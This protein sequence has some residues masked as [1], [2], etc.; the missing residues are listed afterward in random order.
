MNKAMKLKAVMKNLALKKE[1]GQPDALWR[2]RSVRLF[3]H[4]THLPLCAARNPL[5]LKQLSS[6]SE[7]MQAIVRAV[8]R[9]LPA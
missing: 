6:N 8:G 7:Q 5:W 9:R 3:G 2:G 1:S 4:E